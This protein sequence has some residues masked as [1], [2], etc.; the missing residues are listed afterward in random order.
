MNKMNEEITADTTVEQPPESALEFQELQHALEI[1]RVIH[2]PA[3][4]LILAVLSKIDWAEFNFLLT[5][6]GL[7]KGNL[8]K[9]SSKLEEAGYIEIEK[10]YKGRIPVTRYRITPQGKSD[11]QHYWGQMSA[12]GNEIN[13]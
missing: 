2:E 7:S 1:N 5:A 9:Q 11:F 4:L 10:G 6:T 13:T 3:R 12:L 8:S